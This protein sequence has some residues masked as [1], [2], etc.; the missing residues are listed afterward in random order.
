ML[1]DAAFRQQI[2]SFDQVDFSRINQLL[3]A[4]TRSWHMKGGGRSLY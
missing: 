4:T 1:Y 3:Y 2:I